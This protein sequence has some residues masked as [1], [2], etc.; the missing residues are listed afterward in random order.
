V[1]N[2]VIDYQMDGDTEA[3]LLERR[4]FASMKAVRVLQAE[5]ELLADAWQCARSQLAALEAMHEALSEELAQRDPWVPASLPVRR[6]A[7]SAA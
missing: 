6:A 7:S 5:C 2:A 1:E 3:R 4:W